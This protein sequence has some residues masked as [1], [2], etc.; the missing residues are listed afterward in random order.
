M[1]IYIKILKNNIIG[2]KIEFFFDK[3]LPFE[4]WSTWIAPSATVIGDCWL[5]SGVNIWYGAVIK[6]DLSPV[7]IGLWTNIQDGCIITTDD[8]SDIAGFEPEVSIGSYTT[9]GHGVK[10]HACKIGSYCIIGMGSTI[11]E[12]AIIEDGAVIGAGSIVPPGRRVPTQELWL[13]NP[14]KFKRL[15]GNVELSTRESMAIKYNKL[16][17]SHYAQFTEFTKKH[18]EVTKI[19]DKIE[20]VLPIEEEGLPEPIWDLKD[21]LYDNLVDKD[22]DNFDPRGVM[23]KLIKE[24]NLEKQLKVKDEN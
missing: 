3:N 5:S 6:A 23:K 9:I 19:I 13:G 24:K 17:I 8:K 14:A 15:V 18:R 7:K 12:G 20:S 10:L 22:V 11:L 21:K 4:S 1:N 2:I 16:A